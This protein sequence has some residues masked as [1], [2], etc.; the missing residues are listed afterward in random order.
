MAA[1]KKVAGDIKIAIFTFLREI[2]W[3]LFVWQRLVQMGSQDP[4]FV[5]FTWGAGGSTRLVREFQAR[6]CVLR[7]PL[8][9]NFVLN[10]AAT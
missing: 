8:C 4:L 6:I 10:I 7:V 1:L 5:D 3:I 2:N 9:Q